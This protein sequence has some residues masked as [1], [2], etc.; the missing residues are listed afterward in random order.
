M[1][2]GGPKERKTKGNSTPRKQEK[3]N[4]NSGSDVVRGEKMSPCVNLG[5]LNGRVS[6]V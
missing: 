6:G 1:V 5:N 3:I 2:R 4:T